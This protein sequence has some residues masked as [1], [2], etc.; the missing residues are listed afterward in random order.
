MTN[1]NEGDN[2]HLD[3]V[4]RSRM[5]QEELFNNE[6][7][8]YMLMILVIFGIGFITGNVAHDTCCHVIEQLQH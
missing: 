8:I 2:N 7:W 3:T 6:F 1:Q 4:T 5:T